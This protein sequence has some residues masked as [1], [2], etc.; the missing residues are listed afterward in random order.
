MPSG[1]TKAS[2]RQSLLFYLW[3]ASYQ[4]EVKADQ[5]AANASYAKAA[6]YAREVASASMKY[7]SSTRII[8]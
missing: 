1:A 8:G 6:Q 3:D 7:I 4:A 2:L 5:A